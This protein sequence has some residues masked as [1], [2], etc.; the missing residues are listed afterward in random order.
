MTDRRTV[1]GACLLLLLSSGAGLRAQ[2]EQRGVYTSVLDKGGQPVAGLTP[3]D[4]TVREDNVRREVLRVEPATTPMLIALLVD[5]SSRSNNTIRDIRDAA[6]EFVK[7]VTGNGMKNE[8]AVIT[9]AERPTILVDYTSD[10]MKLLKGS[11]IFTQPMS[12]A[13]MLDGIVESAQGMKKRE[14][15]R[16]VIVAIA[17]NGPEL[18]NRYHDQ[19]IGAIKS[20]GAVFDVIM[21]GAPPTDTLTNEGRERAYSYAEGTDSTGGRYDNVLAPSALP[22]RLKQVADELTHQYLVTYAHPQS[23]IPPER[24]TI[25]STRPDLKVRGTPV[26]VSR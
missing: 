20:V 22:A 13:Y 16:P 6:A 11:A 26:K 12:G 19:V 3:A 21:V 18:S 4:F 8:L 17:T 25:S 24:I 10:Q 5:N 2:T 9:V 14:P 15:A 1:I 7:G 23:L